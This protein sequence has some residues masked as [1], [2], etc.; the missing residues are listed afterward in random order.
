MQNRTVLYVR[1][2]STSQ[3]ENSQEYHGVQQ[4]GGISQH[5]APDQNTI[6]QS[7]T[8][9]SAAP[10]HTYPSQVSTPNRLSPSTV[11]NASSSVKK[12]ALGKADFA[13]DHYVHNIHE[14]AQADSSI[15]RYIDSI[16]KDDMR[17]TIPGPY[18]AFQTFCSLPQPL[19][20]SHV[21]PQDA[22]MQQAGVGQGGFGLYTPF[23]QPSTFGG[24]PLP[25]YHPAQHTD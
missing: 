23:P 7:G 25:L 10:P 19:A 17:K 16:H 12:R 1:L 2:E 9:T 5:Q 15:E 18:K 3:H 22:Y 14:A 21:L 20:T 11:L 24:P 4:E 6:P 13:A 8:P